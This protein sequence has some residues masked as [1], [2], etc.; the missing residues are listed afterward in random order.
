MDYGTC[1][2]EPE[3]LAGIGDMLIHFGVIIIVKKLF[4]RN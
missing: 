3:V 4:I 1:S 2:L